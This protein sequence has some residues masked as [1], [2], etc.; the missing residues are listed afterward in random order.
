MTKLNTITRALKGGFLSLLLLI[1]CS[2]IANAAAL[3]SG[4]KHVCIGNLAYFASSVKSGVSTYQWQFGDGFSSTSPEP[5]HLY[6]KTGTY[7]VLL[8]LTMN[9][10]SKSSDSIAIDVDALPSAELFVNPG[11]DSCLYTNLFKAVDKSKPSIQAHTIEKRLILWGDG[12]YQTDL[13]PGVNDTIRHRFQMKDRY[14]IKIEITDIRGCKASATGHFKVIN[15]TLASI[16]ADVTYPAC[17]EAKVCFSNT[18]KTSNGNSQIYIWNFDSSGFQSIAYSQQTCFTTTK[19]KFIRAYLSLSNPDKTCKSEDYINVFLDADSIQ[20]QFR[21]SDSVFCFGDPGAFKAGNSGSGY[22][23][24]WMLDQQLNGHTDQNFIGS[25]KA[26]NLKPGMHIVS[27]RVSKGPCYKDY[28]A[29]FRV[30][31]PVAAMHIF[32]R[33]QCGADERVFFIDTSLNLNK[34]HAEYEWRVIDPEGENCTVHR[35]VNLNKYK[36]CNTS[37]D[38]YGKHDYTIPR[39]KNPIM[40]KVTDTLAGCSD[41]TIQNMEHFHC[42]LCFCRGGF[43]SI[44]QYD[45]FLKLN[46]GE[47]GPKFFSLDTG[48]TWKVFPSEIPKPYK[49][50]YGVS[51]IFE[52]RIPDRAEDFGDDSIKIYRS[53]SVWMDTIFAPGFLFVK[54]AR[55]NNMTIQMEKG[56]CKPFKAIISVEDSLFF[57]GDQVYIEWNDGKSDFI[58]FGKDSV[59]SRFYHSYNIAGMS[60]LVKVTLI[61]RDACPRYKNLELRFGRSIWLTRKGKPCLNES[62]CFEANI[63]NH[64][65]LPAYKHLKSAA[66]ISENNPN[67]TGMILCELY[68]TPGEKTVVFYAEDSLGCRDTITETIQIR[69]LKAGVLQDSKV[70]YCNEM[71]QLFDSSYHLFKTKDDHITEYFWDFGSGMFTTLEKNPFRSFDMKDSTIP[72]T[73]I[74]SDNSG[75]RDTIQYQLTIVGSMPMFTIRDTVGC[76]PFTAVLSNLSRRCAAYIWEFGDLDNN[77]HENNEL[78]AVTFEYRD[79]GK[80]YP[81]LIGIDTFYNP[82]TGSVYYCNAAYDPGQAIT[83]YKNHFSR[84]EAPDTICLGQT[85]VFKCESNSPLSH[86]EYGDGSSIYTSVPPDQF[87]H[88]YL[89]AG[90][91]LSRIRP[92]VSLLPG[93][94]RCIDSA[95]QTIVVLGVQADFEIESKSEAPV[96]YFKN[97]SQPQSADLNWNFGQSASGSSN[98]SSDQNP[99]HNYGVHTGK[100]TICLIASVENKCLDTV[101]KP[102]VNDY[103]QSVRLFNVFTPGNSD[104]LNDD[105]EVSIIGESTYKLI[106]YDRWGVKVYESDA[107]SE[108][109]EGLNWN[110]RLFNTGNDCPAGTYYYLFQYAFKLDPEKS[111]STNGTITLI[112]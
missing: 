99:S 63:E 52:N 44:C 14:K 43:V 45:T 41:S 90:T 38:W 80:F 30:K 25:A 70:F 46:P 18:S 24:S 71:K 79:A 10:G 62:V 84:L 91:F 50:L 97:L 66:W 56:N 110:G 73:H 2:N 51:F 9:D 76:A 13:Y 88:R 89:N 49:G 105:Y 78:N 21:L 22:S 109:G 74:V 98:F 87:Q 28:Q 61:S 100:Y 106:I 69:A 108:P 12:D 26:L 96:F 77:T 85:V 83:V 67:H 92:I 5:F 36:N 23:Y 47:I 15:G 4:P 86:L 48:K 3:I 58:R 102:V 111:Y 64:S 42:K 75:C 33:K 101:C 32:N 1:L 72:V 57:K 104:K 11:N 8:K 59:C 68:K 31:G 20:N 29:S 39:A 112:R 40:L 6:K 53:D 35:A 107:D 19:S 60:G 81:K 94:P 55:N 16:Q 103:V 37:K 65:N 54:E 34:K 95:E 17:G 7:T 27:C 82:Y 93:Q